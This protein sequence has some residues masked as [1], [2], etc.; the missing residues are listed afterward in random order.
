MKVLRSEQQGSETVDA[1]QRAQAEAL[2]LR[3]LQALR[4]ITRA[5]DINSRKLNMEYKVTV[6]QMLCLYCLQREGA[7]T[8]SSLANQVNLSFSTVNGIVD[9]LEAKGWAKRERSTIDHRRVYVTLT[10][11]GCELT[12]NAPSLLQ[13]RF[14]AALRQL[15]ELEQIAIALSLEKVVELMK[16]GNIDVPPNLVP[17]IH[18]NQGN[19]E[20]IT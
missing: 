18:P 14:S 8:L 13:D 20:D 2:G 12:N 16:A 3:V 5:I 7:L 4:R 19:V 1:E 11:T 6:P 15:P 17:D 9:R 10:D